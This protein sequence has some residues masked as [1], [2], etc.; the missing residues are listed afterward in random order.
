MENEIIVPIQIENR[1]KDALSNNL[2][3][4]GALKIIRDNALKSK[5][6]QVTK[7]RQITEIDQYKLVFIGAIG[8]GKTTAICNLFDLIDIHK[9]NK[10]ATKLKKS[11]EGKIITELMT[12][13]AGGTT[14][15]EVVIKASDEPYSFFEIEFL[16]KNEIEAF[17]DD[18]CER[19]IIK[20]DDSQKSNGVIPQEVDRALRN[21]LNL[22]PTQE[23]NPEVEIF[24]KSDDSDTFK[25]Q[26]LSRLNIT[27]SQFETI[28][29]KPE[30]TLVSN[31]E[32]DN[33]NEKKW[34]KDFFTDLNV[35]NIQGF[36]IPKR[37]TLNISNNVLGEDNYLK[38]FHSVIDTKGLDAARD[39]KDIEEYIQK[40][41]TI[42]IFTTRYENA[43]DNNITYLISNYLQN[44][45]RNT[46]QRFITLFLPRGDEPER[47]IA[48][49]GKP[50]DDWEKGI[51]YTQNYIKNVFIGENVKFNEKN[52]LYYDAQQFIVDGLYSSEYKDE[53]ASDKQR[54]I[55]RLEEIIAYR[56]KMDDVLHNFSISVDTII[57]KQLS[58]DISDRINNT[59]SELKSYQHLI[60]DVDF[61]ERFFK[62]FDTQFGHWATKHAINKRHGVW[63]WRE[64]DLTHTAKIVTEKLVRSSASEF[65][66]RLLQLINSLKEEDTESVFNT[67]AEQF[68]FTFLN[69]FNTFVSKTSELIRKR[70]MTNEFD[71]NSNLWST[72]I[73]E[74]GRG[75]G[76]VQRIFA[77]Y[78][79]TLYPIKSLLKIEIEKN[80]K[81]LVIHP[82][83]EFLGEK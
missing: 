11:I 48:Y 76:F 64:I 31:K 38:N 40:E 23:G 17:V 70:L 60:I 16:S 49:D 47:K 67:I 68:E 42:C 15:A 24:K 66:S 32:Q 12:V 61:P 62:E 55:V 5:L 71:Y 27:V 2:E 9:V 6:E 20:D 30:N 39:R 82:L 34:I 50:F 4:T 56:Q 33:K 46:H 29:Y 51:Q 8:S 73:N 59:I 22:K 18:F 57:N 52:I 80:W 83:L 54:I 10:P 35:V 78:N 53:I 43:P 14:I 75:T 45:L 77:D 36:S 44:D 3:L 69:S 26:I 7:I 13:G 65:N 19:V 41:D 74:Y 1:I 79:N 81:A 25:K 21:I 58:P 37:I 63:E 72:L 28:F